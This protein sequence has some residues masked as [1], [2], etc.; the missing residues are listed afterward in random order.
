MKSNRI[1]KNSLFIEHNNIKIDDGSNKQ[2]LT[3]QPLKCVRKCIDDPNCK[4]LNISK[5][6]PDSLYKCSYV[7]NISD[8]NSKVID[9]DSKFFSKIE[10]WNSNGLGGGEY[11]AVT[12]NKC[13]NLNENSGEI[14]WIDNSDNLN[15]C[16]KILLNN[17]NTLQ[18]TQPNNNLCLQIPSEPT[19]NS[20]L[21]VFPCNTWNPQ[22]KF[23]W[24]SISSTL[25]PLSN[26]SLCVKNGDNLVLGTCESNSNDQIIFKHFYDG[27]N[28]DE[29]EN[30]TNI[31]YFTDFTQH[32]PII[33]ITLLIIIYILVIILSK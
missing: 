17:D 23:T 9:E 29:L 15:N 31:E 28:L 10:S 21:F 30:Y 25:R 3:S 12:N 4:G 1:D 27:Y 14:K 24:D 2:D 7:E 13:I 22:Q 8:S 20:K 6:F 33:Y 16:G 32:A 19:I 11:L 26:T 18:F 5:N